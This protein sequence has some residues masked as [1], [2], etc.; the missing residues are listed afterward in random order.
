MK[1]NDL[2]GIMMTRTD[3]FGTALAD[4]MRRAARRLTVMVG[5]CENLPVFDN[6]IELSEARDRHGMPRARVVYRHTPM[7]ERLT[8]EVREEGLAITRA[9]GAREAWVGPTVSHHL[10][11]GTLMG[12]DPA[13]S[14][15]D[16]YGRPHELD[17]LFLIGPNLFPSI[18]HA[19]PTFTLHALALRLARHLG[20]GL[21]A[22]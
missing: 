3:L 1:P 9:A 8:D 22:A 15:T 19:N 11:G 5:A 13:T 20:V 12:A 17:N 6:R 16:S 4:F 18:S 14:V 2:F 10:L 21:Q 7:G